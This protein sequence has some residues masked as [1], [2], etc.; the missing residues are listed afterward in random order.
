[1]AG[2]ASTIDDLTGARQAAVAEN[3][4]RLARPAAVSDADL[5]ACPLLR[6]IGTA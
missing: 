3:V 5:G 2:G 1:V 6:R 4:S